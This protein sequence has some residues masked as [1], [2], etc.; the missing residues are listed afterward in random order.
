ME[1]SRKDQDSKERVFG[2]KVQ[3]VSSQDRLKN[4]TTE[5]TETTEKTNTAA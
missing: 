5:D 3:T 4:F 2:S 1:A